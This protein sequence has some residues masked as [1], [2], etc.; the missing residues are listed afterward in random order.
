MPHNAKWKILRDFVRK[1]QAGAT[2][3]EASVRSVKS[4]GLVRSSLVEKRGVWEK[5]KFEVLSEAGW[6]GL[7]FDLVVRSEKAVSLADFS[8]ENSNGV[9][10]TGNVCLW[11]AEEILTY[12]L[13]A[14]RMGDTLIPTPATLS[15]PPPLSLF[16]VREKRVLE[17]GAGQGVAGFFAA[18]SFGTSTAV[19][20]S[21]T[22]TDGNPMVVKT[23]RENVQHFKESG[24]TSGADVVEAAELKWS[25][26]LTRDDI[27]KLPG[28]SQ[29]DDEP[30]FDIILAADCLF[31][32]AFHTALAH[33]VHL[34]LTCEDQSKY[35]QA[36]FINPSRGRSAEAFVT[37]ASTK[38]E[39]SPFEKGTVSGVSLACV[40]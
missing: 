3:E 27:R 28:A 6:L 23:L 16:D 4:V 10:N 11:P 24:V 13:V 38:L 30:P 26:D 25:E 15:L 36:V 32:K 22:L 35:G 34:A 19:A 33:T 21:I 20:K 31:F 12:L 7:P 5:T 37:L 29:K 9:D 1:T 40:F 14:S 17:I 8:H 2:S 18:T 39:F